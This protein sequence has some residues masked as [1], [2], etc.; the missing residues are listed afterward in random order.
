MTFSLR[1][2]RGLTVDEKRF[3]L[4]VGAPNFLFYGYERIFLL[5]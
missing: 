5:A 2:G 4:S 3:A 1:E